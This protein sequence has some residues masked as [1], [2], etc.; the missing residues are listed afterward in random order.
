MILEDEINKQG[1]GAN[2]NVELRLV[3]IDAKEF[4]WYHNK[5]EQRQNKPLGVIPVLK[6]YETYRS[7]MSQ[8]EGAAFSIS[9]VE[10]FKKG[11]KQKAR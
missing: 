8:S 2:E 1:Q 7:K 4:K 9:C 3:T 5:E 6:I 11:E 10:W